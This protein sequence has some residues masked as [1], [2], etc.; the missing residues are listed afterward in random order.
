[1]LHLSHRVLLSLGALA[2]LGACTRYHAPPVSPKV[3]PRFTEAPTNAPTVRLDAR[4]WAPFGDE[5]LSALIDGLMKQNL[6]LKQAS[7]RVLQLRAVA[8]QVGSQRWPSLN[9]EGSVSRNKQLNQFSRLPTASVSSMDG[10]PT[11]PTNSMPTSFTLDSYRASL[12]VSYELDVWGRLG[13]LTEASERDAVAAE[14]DRNAMAV[15][16]TASAAELWFQLAELK[17]RDALLAQQLK[18]DEELLSLTLARAEEGLAPHL[19]VLQQTQQ[20]DRTR[21]QRPLLAAQEASLTR[22]LALLMG[23]VSQPL[24]PNASLPDLPSLPELGVPAEL[25]LRRPDVRAAQARLAAADARV[26]AAVSARLPSLRIGG[27]LGFQAFEPSELFDDYV[28]GLSSSLLAPIFQA[29]RLSA[30]QSQQEAALK[31]RLFALQERLITAYHEVE[32][33]LSLEREQQRQLKALERV[34]Q[35]GE[36]LVES[37]TSRYLEGLG[38]FL[39]VLNARQGLYAAQLAL[40]SA[41]RATL[42]SRVQLHRAL[43][44]AWAGEG[45]EPTAALAPSA[46]SA[47]LIPSAS[48]TPSASLAR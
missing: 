46:P 20:R 27:N 22:R 21:A 25:L 2:S 15:T 24:T 47:S 28:W 3:A 1:M 39:T 11:S 31:E 23:E 9:F 35:S 34:V 36:E 30:A 42:S 40:L 26:S 17:A 48:L 45:L 19:Q 38:D 8:T 5:G 6:A 44:G 14:Q 37:A 13:S 4:W 33:A 41:R 12:A 32:D 18:A 10:A 7:Q 43:G 29:G 16:L